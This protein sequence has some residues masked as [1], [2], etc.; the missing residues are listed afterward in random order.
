MEY[1]HYSFLNSAYNTAVNNDWQTGG[2]MSEIK[3]RLGYRF[4]MRNGTYPTV[5]AAGSLV[6]FTL[7]FENVGFAAPFNERV[8]QMVLR[9]AVTNQEYKLTINGTHADVRFWHRG[10]ISLEGSFHLPTNMPSGDYELWLH[11]L[12][13]ANNNTIADRP[14]Y[15]IRL[16]NT[17]TWESGSGYND[18][19]HTLS[20]FFNLR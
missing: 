9:H 4:V 8:L 2:C 5:A 19:N 16:A 3:K 18:L 20:V 11:I 10:N 14:A 13:P 1:L 17:N 15:S 7:N 12:D 6:N